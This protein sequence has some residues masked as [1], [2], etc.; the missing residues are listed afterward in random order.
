[1]ASKG[2]KMQFKSTSCLIRRR[3]IANAKH[4]RIASGQ[5]RCIQNRLGQTVCETSVKLIG[6]WG[7]GGGANGSA[8]LLNSNTS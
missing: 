5:Q 4:N 2:A 8:M 7:T 3:I 1:M 6:R